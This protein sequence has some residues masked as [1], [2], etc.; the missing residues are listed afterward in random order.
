MADDFASL[1]FGTHLDGTAASHEEREQIAL[2]AGAGYLDASWGIVLMNPLG[3]QFSRGRPP[4]QILTDLLG[5]NNKVNY[6]SSAHNLGG[7]I[8]DVVAIALTLGE[9]AAALGAVRGAS[10]A[11]RGGKLGAI[12]AR[13][14]SFDPETPVL[15][16]DG[17]KKK[18]K[19]V[20]VGD[21]VLA[22]DD[23]TGEVKGA[24]KVTVLHAARHNGD[25]IDL[26]VVDAGGVRRLIRTTNDHPFWD[27]TTKRWTKA[28]ELAAGHS[29]R[30]VH[31]ELV[32]VASVV[33]R[34]GSATMLNLTISQNHTYYVVAGTTPVLVHNACPK[35]IAL[36]LT[37]TEKN[38]DALFEFGLDRG[39]TPWMGWEDPGNPWKTFN[40]ALH[41]NSN[42]DI[43]FNLD[44]IRD[45]KGWAASG[46]ELTAQELAA[47]RDAPASVQNRVTWWENGRK[48]ESPFAP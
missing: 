25:L 37:S 41:P 19:D 42:V 29:L 23:G 21:E 3:Q 17:S 32:Y 46:G 27:E 47:I 26:A 16:A 48:V 31:N 11:G 13:A 20:D 6:N 10:G 38:P 8:A 40:K 14:C 44:G 1:Y 12:A 45:P 9:G 34:P 28:G 4:S 30:S 39:A 43:H 5:V 36:G 7:L 22:A 35:S 15:L 2:D 24:R 18:I 33:S